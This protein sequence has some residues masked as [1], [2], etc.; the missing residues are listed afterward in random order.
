MGVDLDG[1]RLDPRATYIVVARHPLD[2]AV[3][4]YH[5]RHNI[6][7]RRLRSLTGHT[8][9]DRTDTPPPPLRLP[10]RPGESES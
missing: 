5:H 10:R 3:S 4:L 6:D 2:M 1:I 7:R 8:E 9:P